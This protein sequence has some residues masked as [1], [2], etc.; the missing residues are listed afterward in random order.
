[1]QTYKYVFSWF[2]N[3][4]GIRIFVYRGVTS[5]SITK[6]GDHC[7]TVVDI[8][9]QMIQY[10]LIPIVQSLNIGAVKAESYN[11]HMEL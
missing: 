9:E 7:N 6:A 11:H 8:I 10:G 2:K 3:L 4:V 5:T 1:M